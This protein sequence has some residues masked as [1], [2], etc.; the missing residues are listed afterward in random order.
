M[1]QAQSAQHA[2]AAATHRAI[3]MATSFRTGDQTAT[4]RR[5]L[6]N[7]EGHV[8]L[9]WGVNGR[10]WVLDGRLTVLRGLPMRAVASPCCRAW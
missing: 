3:S 2:T 6:D 4:L 9:L 1:P 7:S 10:L 5:R 8:A